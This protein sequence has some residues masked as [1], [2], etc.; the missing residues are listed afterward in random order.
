MQIITPQWDI[1]TTRPMIASHQ[2]TA[3]IIAH[4][5]TA[6]AEGFSVGCEVG[7]GFLFGRGI[8]DSEMQLLEGMA[9][10]SWW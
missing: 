9:V 8:K 3:K 6:R 7:S 1:I 4:S 2:K 10:I 5:D